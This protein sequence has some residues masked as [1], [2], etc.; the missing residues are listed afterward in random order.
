MSVW[1]M[2]MK[3]VWKCILNKKSHIYP[4]TIYSVFKKQEKLK[5]KKQREKIYKAH[6][7]ERQLR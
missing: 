3:E 2:N 5:R 7:D 4:K 6:H 1:C